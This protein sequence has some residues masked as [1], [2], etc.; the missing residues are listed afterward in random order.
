VKLSIDSD[1]H[2][3]A[4]FQYLKFGIGQARRGFARK[5]DVINTY[6]V[7]R[8]LEFLKDKQ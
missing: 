6:P 5:S 8:M 1:A 7:Q 4:H 3:V 2:H